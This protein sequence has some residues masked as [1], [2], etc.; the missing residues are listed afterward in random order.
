MEVLKKV[1]SYIHTELAITNFR[2]GLLT[3]IITS[4]MLCAIILYPSGGTTKSSTS[5]PNDS[6][7]ETFFHSRFILLSEFLPEICFGN[8]RRNNFCILF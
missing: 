4:L 6:F 7:F 8:R 5:A 1:Y 3:Q 2:S